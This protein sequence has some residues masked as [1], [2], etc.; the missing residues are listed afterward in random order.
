MRG[1]LVPAVHDLLARQLRRPRGRAAARPHVTPAAAPMVPLPECDRAPAPGVGGIHYM[2]RAASKY[3]QHP[4][5]ADQNQ[6]RYW[7]GSTAHHNAYM[8]IRGPNN[9]GMYSLNACRL[10]RK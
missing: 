5:H 4:G 3:L 7:L 9:I 10:R 6:N 1:V 8:L 2:Q